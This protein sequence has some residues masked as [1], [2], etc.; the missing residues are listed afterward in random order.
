MWVILFMVGNIFIRFLSSRGVG[1]M[2]VM[3]MMT[4][5][6]D[7]DDIDAVDVDDAGETDD[8]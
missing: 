7:A 2:L 4:M 3:P 5:L 1:L 8:G 6:A